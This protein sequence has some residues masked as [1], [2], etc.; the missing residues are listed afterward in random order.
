[1]LLYSCYGFGVSRLWR[2][3]F[4]V[5]ELLGTLKTCRHSD[6]YLIVSRF[7]PLKDFAMS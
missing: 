4:N 3:V 5:A 6:R 2:H 1:M 7:I